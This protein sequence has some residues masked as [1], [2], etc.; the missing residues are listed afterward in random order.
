MQTHGWKEDW[1]AELTSL[2]TQIF[3]ERHGRFVTRELFLR[4]QREASMSR[5]VSQEDL[6]H[7]PVEEKWTE[8]KRREAEAAKVGELI[9][10]TDGRASQ[11]IS[12]R[13]LYLRKISALVSATRPVDETVVPK[14]PR[15]GSSRWAEAWP[16]QR[17]LPSQFGCPLSE[18]GGQTN[19]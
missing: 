13:I 8:F 19:R 11:A 9:S 15:I 17:S 10:G 3:Y 7:L 4:Q 12:S 6:E 18:K 2:K 1:G 14:P 5:S 16:P